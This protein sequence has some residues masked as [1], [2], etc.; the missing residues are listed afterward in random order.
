[1]LV[2]RTALGA[3]ASAFS[4]ALLGLVGLVAC[5]DKADTAIYDATGAG[6]A[7]N[8]TTSTTGGSTLSTTTATAA[9]TTTTSSTGAGGMP[10]LALYGAPL[11]FAPTSS[12]FRVSAVVQSGDPSELRARIR[13]EGASEWSEAA[14]PTLRTPDLAEWHFEGLQP[15]T[16]YDYDVSIETDAQSEVF[17]E[18]STVTQRE[19]GDDF[20]FAMLSDT[21][22][23]AYLTYSNQGYPETL[24]AISA[25]VAA[26]SPDFVLNLGDMLDFHQFGF[27]APPPSGQITR[28]AYQNYRWLL[29]DVAG[30]MSHFPV[31]GNWD[32]EAG[33]YPEETIAYSREQRQLYVPAPEPG[34][35]PEGGG[36]GADYYAYTWGDALFIVLNVMSYT[37]A[38]HM[39]TE[40][41]V[42]DDWTLGADQLA[43]FESTLEAASSKWR[44]VF[45]HH[46]VGGAAGDAANSNYG[47]GGGQAAYVG[48][49]ATVHALMQEH[50]VQ[51]FFYGHDHVFYDM[52]V[53][54]IH[55]S[56]PGS[57]GAPWK[58]TTEETGYETYWDESGWALVDVSS[59]AVHVQ[60][61]AMGGALLYE[62][63]LE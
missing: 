59:E 51:V 11:L 37:T 45:I 10:G 27:N 54:G 21:H 44:F 33:S 2:T 8:S 25:E 49:Q 26:A 6:G 38:E 46:T 56:T 16:R 53:D 29:G 18:G 14:E 3:C 22:I 24:T 61:I 28:L 47:R 57:A 48:E 62:Y 55:Y 15:G 50:G 31:I 58:F 5:S 32:G 39:L 9:T 7:G 43:W 13:L 42:P 17:Y 12:S 36:P 1:V 4:C 35:Y 63:T 41:E 60:F 23:G 30:Q 34:T 19:A 52:V 20:A 40:E